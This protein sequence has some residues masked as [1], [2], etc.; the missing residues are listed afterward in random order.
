MTE[1]L[2]ER[3]NQKGFHVRRIQSPIDFLKAWNTVVRD[4]SG[5]IVVLSDP[6]TNLWLDRYDNVTWVPEDAGR[7]VVFRAALGFTG[8]S[9]ALA[10]TGTVMLAEDSGYARLVSN[11]VPRHIALI[12]E[13]RIA[14]NWQEAVSRLRQ[15]SSHLPRI[16]SFISGPSQTADI[17][18][19]LIRGMHGPIHVEA[20]LVPPVSGAS[21]L[22]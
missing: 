7:D 15:E 21:T 12:P 10:D 17:Q 22:T 5:P 3:L 11:M 8:V 6:I 9:F 13:N 19:T 2:I 14:A 1:H 20:W 16:L 18:G 4:V